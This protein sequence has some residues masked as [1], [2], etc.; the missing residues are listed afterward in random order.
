[1][2]LLE[3]LQTINKDAFLA[4]N[5]ALKG[6]TAINIIH[7]REIPRLSVDLDFDLARNTPQEEML[8]VKDEVS[9]KIRD[10]A[11]SMGY[12]LSDPRPNYVIHQTELYYCSATGNRDKIKLDINRLS[13]SLTIFPFPP[14]LIF[15]WHWRISA[16][17]PFRISRSNCFP[18]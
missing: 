5:L 11:A 13:A 7:Y 14:A 9:A 8:H 3:L 18:C 2:R 16:S 15:R 10:L 6:G 4:D 12:L 17:G 1:M